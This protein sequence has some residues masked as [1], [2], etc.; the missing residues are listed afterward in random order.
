MLKTRLRCGVGGCG[1]GVGFSNPNPTHAVPY[2]GTA[3]DVPSD[4]GKAPEI[5]TV[6][7]SLPTPSSI[8]SKRKHS[9]IT[10]STF[11]GQDSDRKSLRSMHSSK[12]VGF[13]S[14]AK[15][16]GSASSVSR[17]SKSKAKLTKSAGTNNGIGDLA[18]LAAVFKSSLLPQV[19]NPTAHNWMEAGKAVMEDDNGLDGVQKAKVLMIFVK[20]AALAEMYL[21]VR[22]DK[23]VMDPFLKVILDIT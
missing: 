4:K 15:V 3:I 13:S 12:S 20:D 22:K 5:N 18:E 17:S 16:A 8:S 19:L 21:L 1:C 14:A 7:Q 6:V 2:T 23:S 9:V 11:S 10:D